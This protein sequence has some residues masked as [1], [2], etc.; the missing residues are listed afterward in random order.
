MP[1]TFPR[2]FCPINGVFFDLERISFSEK[3][4]SPSGLNTVSSAVAPSRISGNGQAECAAGR[5]REFFH[6]ITDRQVFI[7]VRPA[8]R[9][10]GLQ[11]GHAK[12]GV[13]EFQVFGLCRRGCGWYR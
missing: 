6:K 7:Q 8:Q 12:F 11:P 9:K 2:R 1:S 10:G 3:T 5:Y 4:N 13:G